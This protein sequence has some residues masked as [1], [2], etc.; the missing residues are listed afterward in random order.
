LKRSF[1][2]N[3]L[4]FGDGTEVT[5]H[6]SYNGKNCYR[7]SKERLPRGTYETPIRGLHLLKE[8]EIFGVGGTQRRLYAADI[9]SDGEALMAEKAHS[10]R[11]F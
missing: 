11:Y 9:M 10:L 4:V 8:A 3:T 1:I 6:T 2:Q 7:L 5:I